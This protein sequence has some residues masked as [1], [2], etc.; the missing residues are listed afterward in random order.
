MELDDRTRQG[1][2]Q[3]LD[4]VLGP[5]HAEVLMGYLPPVGWADV[6]TK[7][8]LD[9]LSARFEAMLH[10]EIGALRTELGGQ[11][12]ALRTEVRGEIGALRGEIGALRTEVGGEIGALRGEI[13]ALRTEVGGEIGSVRAETGSVRAEIGD[14]RAEFTKQTRG[15]FFALAGLMVTLT[16]VTIAAI[17]VT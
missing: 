1:L 13:G 9:L 8:D 7:H 12:G 16:G 15:L 6:A 10:R 3:R 4:D 11:I 5:E 17:T 14:L 2:F